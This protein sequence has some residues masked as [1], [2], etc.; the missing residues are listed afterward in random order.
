MQDTHSGKLDLYFLVLI[1]YELQ[2]SCVAE[3]VDRRN[4]SR[5]LR[6]RPK[7]LPKQALRLLLILI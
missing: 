4:E 1:R 7:R 6:N 5:I 2:V 3:L